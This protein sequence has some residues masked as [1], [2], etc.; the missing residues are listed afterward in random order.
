[1]TLSNSGDYIPGECQY[2]SHSCSSVGI[3]H[4]RLTSKI[5]S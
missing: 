5:K 4:D 2:R 3:N 1:M